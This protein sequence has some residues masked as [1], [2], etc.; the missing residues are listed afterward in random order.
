MAT[1]ANTSPYFTS[2]QSNG[3]LNVWTYRDFPAQD[4]DILYQVELKYQNRP[5]LLSYDLYNTV[6]L[7]WVFAIRNPSIIQDPVFDLVSGIQIYIPKITTLKSS[8]GF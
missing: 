8:L 1:Y 3:Y 2:D 5:D 7:W 6:A 4:D